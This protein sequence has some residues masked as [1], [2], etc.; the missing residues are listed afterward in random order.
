MG[1][2]LLCKEKKSNYLSIKPGGLVGESN[3]SA[4]WE[5]CGKESVYVC[6][7]V[8][9]RQSAH[10]YLSVGLYVHECDHTTWSAH[11]CS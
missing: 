1:V 9:R 6:T 3:G 10:L 8:Y 2:I 4:L 11:V 7:S 5:S